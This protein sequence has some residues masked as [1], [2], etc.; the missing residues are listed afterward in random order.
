VKIIPDWYD[1]F[2]SASL[3]YTTFKWCGTHLTAVLCI[4][5]SCHM[6]W[7]TVHVEIFICSACLHLYIVQLWPLTCLSEWTHNVY[8][9][10]CQQLIFFHFWRPVTTLQLFSM[11]GYCH[12][13]LYACV[14]G[15]PMHFCK[16]QL[17][18]PCTNIFNA[19]WTLIPRWS[20]PHAHTHTHKMCVHCCTYIH[21]HLMLTS[22]NT[23]NM[24]SNIY[25]LW[26]VTTF[27]ARGIVAITYGATS[28]IT[29]SY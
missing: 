6:V 2:C 13:V 9:D 18:L 23:C 20:W 3:C 8:H 26:H 4:L 28:V 5:K 21:F 15:S 24:L 29:W 1:L 7:S 10:V 22:A 12:S 27:V 14:H 19:V 17:L 16:A 11:L 25:N